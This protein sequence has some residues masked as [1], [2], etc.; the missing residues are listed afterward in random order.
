MNAPVRLH[1]LDKALEG[2]LEL[3]VLS[4]REEVVEERMRVL[5]G[6]LLDFLRGRGVA[7]LCL[8]RLRQIERLEEDDLKLLGRIEV[9][10]VVFSNLARG[11]LLLRDLLG[12]E[13]EL[14]LQA[15]H[16]HRD[17]GGLHARED[18][19]ERQLEVGVEFERV[20]LLEVRRKRHGQL[21]DGERRIDERGVL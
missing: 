20:D 12:K 7:G 5:R 18:A 16:V 1:R 6:K 8:L 15:T 2:D 13:L 3:L 9:E 11:L 14:V 19:R 17:A 10:L 4:V 21:R